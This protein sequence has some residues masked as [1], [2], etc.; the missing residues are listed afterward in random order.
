LLSLQGA[1]AASRVRGILR[2]CFGK[3]DVDVRGLP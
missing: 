3:I 1:S 2:G